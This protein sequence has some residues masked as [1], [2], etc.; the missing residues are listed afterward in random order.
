MTAR[1]SDNDLFRPFYTDKWAKGAGVPS[2]SVGI[3]LLPSPHQSCTLSKDSGHTICKYFPS[4][5]AVK[6]PP[7]ALWP[8]GTR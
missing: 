2:L 8:I 5:S 7:P 1:A 3:L 4:A 6:Y